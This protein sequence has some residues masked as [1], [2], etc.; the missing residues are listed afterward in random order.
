MLWGRKGFFNKMVASAMFPWGEKLLPQEKGIIVWSNF[1]LGEKD[2][3]SKFP[4]E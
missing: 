1:P 2:P 3:W 4:Y